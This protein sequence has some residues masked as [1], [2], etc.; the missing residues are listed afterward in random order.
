MITSSNLSVAEFIGTS[1][2]ILSRECPTAY[3]QMCALL[4]PRKVLL[5]IDGETVT[6]AFDQDRVH[7]LP[8]SRSPTIM[9]HTTRQTILDVIDYRM[10]LSEAVLVDAILLQGDVEDLALFHEGLLTYVCGAVRCPSFPSLLDRFQQASSDLF[11][12]DDETDTR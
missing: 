5:S 11:H 4:M 1:L 12:R 10:T 2:A 7:M 9:L 8:Q 6:L 3:L